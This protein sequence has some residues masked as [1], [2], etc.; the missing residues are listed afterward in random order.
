MKVLVPTGE[1]HLFDDDQFEDM[2]WVT[3]ARLNTL[4]KTK[5]ALGR[6]GYREPLNRILRNIMS[7]HRQGELYARDWELYRIGVLAM[8]LDMLS[9]EAPDAFKLF[10]RTL[11]TATM[12]EYFGV[13]AGRSCS[14]SRRPRAR[15][16][17]SRASVR[18]E[19]V[20]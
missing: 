6:T 1:P 11:K 13:R 8:A 9:T 12:N 18:H 19:Q 15:C 17:R 3:V 14:A 10:R 4:L 16:T 7:Y 5:Y 2:F 20:V